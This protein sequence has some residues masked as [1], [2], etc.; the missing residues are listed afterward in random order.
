MWTM[1]AEYT[2]NLINKTELLN[3]KLSHLSSDEKLFIK[4]IATRV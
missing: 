4:K 2:S 3:K 1:S